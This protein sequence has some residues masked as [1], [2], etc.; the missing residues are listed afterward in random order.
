MSDSAGDLSSTVNLLRIQACR[1]GAQL[2]IPLEAIIYASCGTEVGGGPAVMLF[3]ANNPITSAMSMRAMADE[4]VFV[5]QREPTPTQEGLTPATLRFAV[6]VVRHLIETSA[7]PF[8]AAAMVNIFNHG[9]GTGSSVADVLR[10]VLTKVR[11]DQLCGCGHSA[12]NLAELE[13]TPDGLEIRRYNIQALVHRP[14]LRN[15]LMSCAKDCAKKT[16]DQM[17]LSLVRVAK[18]C[19]KDDMKKHGCPHCAEL[20]YDMIGD[21]GLVDVTAYLVNFKGD[22]SDDMLELATAASH[23]QYN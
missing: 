13:T 1:R 2:R 11:G 23:V 15:S 7:P 9:Y 17:L 18:K 21:A 19:P 4:T 5:L 14:A 12:A 16:A 22:T 8:T 3:D 6:D 20:F 10:L